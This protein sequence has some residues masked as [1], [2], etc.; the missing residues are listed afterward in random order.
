M[1]LEDEKKECSKSDIHKQVS[2][3][4]VSRGDAC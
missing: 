1:S 2:V 4:P 3:W